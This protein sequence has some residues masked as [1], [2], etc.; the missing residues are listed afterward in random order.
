MQRTNALLG[1]AIFFV[2]APGTVAGVVPWLIGHWRFD[3]PLL[4]TEITRWIGIALIIAGLP[5]L[6]DSFLRFAIQG[7]GTPA[8]IAPT[9]HLVI[10]GL[11][12]YVRNPMYVAVASL[13]FGQGLLFGNLAIIVYG[14]FV[15]I[16]FHLFVCYYEE[17]TLRKT[18]GQEYAAYC[19]RVPRWVP[20]PPMAEGAKAQS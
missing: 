20:R 11:Y 6:I 17:P 2:V 8:P 16:A 1:S 15:C 10:S 19:A 14:A 4:G 13:I 18:F 7:I 5:G 3:A 9:E 12:R